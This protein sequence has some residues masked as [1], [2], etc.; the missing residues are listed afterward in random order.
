MAETVKL[1]DLAGVKRRGGPDALEIAG[2]R[3]RHLFYK[4]DSATL[5]RNHLLCNGTTG[6]PKR[7]GT[8][9]LVGYSSWNRDTRA[10][11][12]RACLKKHGRMLEQ[13]DA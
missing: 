10:P 3:V 11:R 8:G 9:F 7:S 5:R 4:K 6:Y 12:C 1:R 2:G 13:S